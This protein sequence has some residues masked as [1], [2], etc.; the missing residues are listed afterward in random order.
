MKLLDALQDYGLLAGGHRLCELIAPWVGDHTWMT[1]ECPMLSAFDRLFAVAH[2]QGPTCRQ[3]YRDPGG[4]WSST[5]FGQ[6]P[7]LVFGI[8]VSERVW[9]Q[10]PEQLPSGRLPLYRARGLT[11][12]LLV[13]L[14]FDL[15][16]PPGAAA[17]SL[18]EFTRMTGS[19]G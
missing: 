6:M 10:A 12:L 17:T 9:S 1:R 7:D 8:E 16:D 2:M 13:R 14:R 11:P 3:F 15:R 4:W 5:D 19:G 18:A